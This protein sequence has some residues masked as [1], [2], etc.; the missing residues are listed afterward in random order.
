MREH[1][2]VEYPHQGV[3]HAL[4]G[5]DA[6]QRLPYA[7]FDDEVF[8]RDDYLRDEQRDEHE[9]PSA[10]PLDARECGEDYCVNEIAR[11]VEREFRARRTSGGRKSRAPLVV[12]NGVERPEHALNGEQPQRR[13][14]AFS[15]SA[16]NLNFVKP[17]ALA[18]NSDLRGRSRPTQS[19]DAPRT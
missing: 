9:R 13:R 16:F 10:A 17:S 2:A 6:A 15:T 8:E 4:A 11:G 19:S 18:L 1:R 14:Q 12:V 5:I 3:R 7:V